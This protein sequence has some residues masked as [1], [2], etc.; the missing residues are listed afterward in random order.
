MEEKLFVSKEEH[1]YIHSNLSRRIDEIESQVNG[2]GKRLTKT[3]QEIAR[4]QERDQAQWQAIAK[5]EA[6]IDILI[7]KIDDI[8]KKSVRIWEAM[9]LTFLG[10]II[11]VLI[12]NVFK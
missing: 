10:G 11:G 9:I 6:K 2:F 3:E 12:R 1:N 8:T 5:L 4:M 7:N